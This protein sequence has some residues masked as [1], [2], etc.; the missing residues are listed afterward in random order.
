MSFKSV[1]LIPAFHSGSVNVPFSG[2]F[3]AL[4][5]TASAARFAAKG[6][7]MRGGRR[8]SDIFRSPNLRFLGKKSFLVSSVNL[9]YQE[10]LDLC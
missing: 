2:A 8:E 5:V 4:L 7:K 9:L 6:A 10:E 3:G 1:T